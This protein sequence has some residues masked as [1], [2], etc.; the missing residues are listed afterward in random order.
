MQTVA[1]GEKQ[2]YNKTAAERQQS[3]RSA[4]FFLADAKNR[5][6]QNEHSAQGKKQRCFCRKEGLQKP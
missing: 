5:R 2:K 6:Q 3:C 4:A 1:A